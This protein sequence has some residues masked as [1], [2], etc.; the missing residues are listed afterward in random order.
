MEDS[1]AAHDKQR[2][3]RPTRLVLLLLAILLIG[4]QGDASPASA[5][6][7]PWGEHTHTAPMPP[8]GRSH[9]GL[10]PSATVPRWATGKSI[11]FL[12][13][14]G[15][16]SALEPR[17]EKAGETHREL[18]R[19]CEEGYL[20][21]CP[22]PPVRYHEG[23][24]VQHSPQVHVI[25]WGK[26]WEAAP[27]AEVKTQLLKM[28]NGLSGSA[29][30]EILTQ[31][32]DTTG[33]VS[34]TP[35]ITSWVDT[36][37]AAP[38]SV[39]DQ[40]IREEIERALKAEANKTWKREFNSQFVV[41]PAPKTAYTLYSTFTASTTNGSPT[42][43][44]VSSFANLAVG[45]VIDGPGIPGEIAEVTAVNPSA[46]TATISKSVNAT[47]SNVTFKTAGFDEGFCGYHSID[48]SGSSYTFVAYPAEAP[49][50]EGCINFDPKESAANVT[51]M[52]SSH[53]YAESATDPQIEIANAEW[54]DTEGYELADICASGD[55]EITSGSLKGSFVQ[56]LWDDHQN[57]CSLADEKPPHILAITESATNLQTHEATLKGLVNPEGA[58]AKY[59]FEYGPTSSYGSRTAEASGGS[60]ISNL[61][62]SKTISGLTLEGT[63]HYRIVA[64]NSSGTT[65]GEDHTV[66]L[67]R[68]VTQTTPHPAES[69]AASLSR[70]A[71]ASANACTAVGSAQIAGETP[72]AE[73]WNGSAWSLQTV[74]HSS[75]IDSLGEVACGSST[76]CMALGGYV[77]PETATETESWNGTEWTIHAIA[78]PSGGKEVVLSGVSC[79]SATACLGVGSFQNSE[80]QYQNLAESWNGS[81]WA[82]Q[83]IPSPVGAKS[84]GLSGISCT[85]STACTAVGG[86]KNSAGGFSS[87]AE[88]WNGK[89]WA[90]QTTPN[91][92]KAERSY[93]HAV[94]CASASSC[95]AVGFW[96][97]EKGVNEEPLVEHWNGTEWAIESTPTP[98]G[99]NG[100][101]YLLGVSCVSA[102][103]CT[104][105]GSYVIKPAPEEESLT[106]SEAWNGTEWKVQ[107]PQNSEHGL[108]ELLG[109]AC[110]ATTPETCESVGWYQNRG[111][112]TMIAQRREAIT[113][114]VETTAASSIGETSVTANGF[115]TPEG[116]ETKYWFEYGIKAY[117]GKTAEAGAG[118]GTAKR[119]ESKAVAGL[120]PSTTYKVRIV[121]E[122][123]GGKT[124]AKNLK[125]FS[126]TGK[127]TVET[128]PATSVG[129]TEA[130]LKGSINPRGYETKYYFE[131]GP[132]ESYGS[133]TAE[134][135][136]GKGLE[137]LHESQAL[138]GLARGTF[139]HFRI[140]ATN[141][142][143]TTYGSDVVLATTSS[144]TWRLGPEPEQQPEWNSADL[145]SVSCSAA[146]ACTAVGRYN[147]GSSELTTSPFAERWNGTKWTRQTVP[148]HAGAKTTYLNGAACPSAS[149]CIAVGFYGSAERYYALGERWNG[150][151]WSI[152]STPEPAGATY[153]YIWSVS[154]ASSSY[155]VA[156]GTYTTST[157]A[158]MPFAETWNGTK[159]TEQTP[160]VPSGAKTAALYGISCVS[161]SACMAVG[162][163]ETS[164]G[165]GEA[166]ADRWNGTEWSLQPMA[167][168]SGASEPY[169]VS[170][171]C[172]SSST[173]A[174]LLDYGGTGPRMG[175]QRWN[176]TSWSVEATA[177]VP[178]ATAEGFST[179][180]C[181]ASASCT[182]VGAYENAEA[183]ELT[184]AEHWNGSGWA[185]QETTNLGEKR[186]D[187]LTGV[188]CQSAIA[189]VAVGTGGTA[190]GNRGLS[191][192]YE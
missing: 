24:G 92:A 192:I 46:K 91:P 64:T 131:Y 8:Q 108:N 126:T 163:D 83:S 97:A 40:G 121:A 39:N 136:A 105:V 15:A 77:Y 89:E 85:S 1:S 28:Y 4:A 162:P 171:A 99:L 135:S 179:I 65:G 53:E 114:V 161:A 181:G 165:V 160:P 48:A 127:P 62:V 158:R 68:W 123:S 110:L 125:T 37:V 88:R 38:Q 117:E 54:Y 18:G 9:D 151:E 129:E 94:S 74:P 140:V 130:T 170:V 13:R 66:T 51:S 29:W 86:Y 104:L 176:G 3:S 147:T 107:A 23:K 102:T 186:D 2:A 17:L 95:T 101:T 6:W 71:C 58:E 111:P 148:T 81:A 144:G 34:T 177:T 50:K 143:G 79:Y 175:A 90:I 26:N 178:G 33:R 47:A 138:T 12:A 41:I 167:L 52:I 103:N 98:P 87:L 183:Q 57:A 113:P 152:V 172:T 59:F 43:T 112:E 190:Y 145:E 187:E 137:E 42:L 16:E 67:S 44:S 5:K 141:S 118:A 182:A 35:T 169:P 96:F 120:V 157:T 75:E 31:Y 82:L 72:V 7:P 159:W 84:T 32:F 149:E 153:A 19:R 191:E 109:V 70:V 20:G 14:P 80:A 154:C 10:G 139:Y 166:F 188:S 185:L 36:S 69:S 78:A 189:C 173:C 11:H 164:A 49:F 115:V 184:V 21:Y 180:S 100:G 116:Y 73:R 106:L 45:E 93:L 134:V 122:N 27:G 156:M 155:C 146:N 25:F 132:T 119:E 142:K 150:S 133:K 55:D 61:E 174:A 22:K 168:P 63:Y 60:G 124:E 128:E 76:A 30:Q 56:G